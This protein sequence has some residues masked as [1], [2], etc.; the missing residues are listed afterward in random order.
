MNGVGI[1]LQALA[2]TGAHGYLFLSR[3]LADQLVRSLG[4][5]YQTL[6]YPMQVTGYDSKRATRITQYLRLHLTVDG[7]RV[8]NAPFIVL[9]LGKHN[10]IIGV[11][12]MRRFRLLLDP[13]RNR[14]KWPT[15]Y[16]RTNAFVKDIL[17]QYR[18]NFTRVIDQY[19]QAD[20]DRRDKA[21]NDDDKRKRDGAVTPYSTALIPLFVCRAQATPGLLQIRPGMGTIDE[22]KARSDE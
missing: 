17:I 10:C 12:F 15:E 18:P 8:Y 5:S 19:R 16:P 21:I 6:P 9:D 11:K 22:N 7:R 2:D 20:A 14:F 1:A 13:S 3:T 4:I